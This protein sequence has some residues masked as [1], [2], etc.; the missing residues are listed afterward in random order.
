MPRRLAPL[1]TSTIACLLLACG[2][3]S[4]PAAPA[5]SADAKATPAPPAASAAPEAP[6]AA[7]ATAGTPAAPA[8]GTAAAPPAA[9]GG[10]RPPAKP[11]A[12]DPTPPPK[13][14]V[15]QAK[16][17]R[18]SYG[19]ALNEGRKLAKAD[20]WD[21]A[22]V[23]LEAAR[24][25]NPASAKVLGELGWA[26]FNA[27]QLDK[28]DATL[29]LALERVTNDGTRGALLYNLGRVAEARGLQ[30]IAAE[31]YLQ[32]L[33]HRQNAT[34]KQRL[35]TL[36]AAGVPNDPASSCGFERH[37][38]VLPIDLCATL[39]ADIQGPSECYE[40]DSAPYEFAIAGNEDLP[41]GGVPE[42]MTKRAVSIDGLD[43][44]VFS[45]HTFELGEAPMY[46]AIGNESQ[47]WWTAVLDVAYNP[48]MGYIHEDVAVTRVEAIDLGWTQGKTYVIE[49][50]YNRNDGDM[51]TNEIEFIEQRYTTVVAVP[52]P[53]NPEPPRFLFF[54][55]T[56]Y[57]Y[58][59]D[60]FLDDIE[61]TPDGPSEPHS[62]ALGT[63]E[64]RSATVTFTPGS[65]TI[66]VS[67]TTTPAASPTG[68]YEL[69]KSV[70]MCPAQRYQLPGA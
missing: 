46:L 28:A 17:A 24:T 10:T 9:E 20:K 14:T 35:D 27:G 38:G 61:G 58:G 5:A 40:S 29:Q 33:I 12:P 44:A 18:A 60:I 19:K 34:V 59:V 53:R 48:G 31:R 51:A 11:L 23:Q 50:T 32:S 39:A 56:H 15:E 70:L 63:K 2:A 8:A 42:R 4:G 65:P 3:P 64:V 21:E 52:P 30:A 69:G 62:A 55:R 7:D 25:A 13:P 47:H 22:L 26:Q 6:A 45:L 37:A 68:T 54:A 41:E 1:A 49:W 16:A 36:I 66:A 67:S 57:E 43:I